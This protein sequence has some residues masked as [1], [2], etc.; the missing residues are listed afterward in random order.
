MAKK[1][2]PKKEE[3]EFVPVDRGG[4]PLDTDKAPEAKEDPA[5]DVKPVKT[6]K[7]R[8]FRGKKRPIK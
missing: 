6:P 1:K 8:W 4:N 3:K 7:Y 5:E 2:S